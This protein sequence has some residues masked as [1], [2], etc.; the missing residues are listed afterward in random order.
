MATRSTIAR[1]NADH[2]VTA[3][4]CH[5]DGYVH[6]NGHILKDHYMD[7]VKIDQLINLGALSSLRPLIGEK[8]DF[9]RPTDEDWCVVYGRDRGEEDVAARTHTNVQAWL[10][11][12]EEYNYLWDGSE[13]H[14]AGYVT[15]HEL[16]SL[17]QVILEGEQDQD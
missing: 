4:Y 9:D 15:N 2:T 17:V 14:V 10:D 11:N 7:P 16:R 13:W 12:G 3:I 5:W 6:H 8:Q 1:L